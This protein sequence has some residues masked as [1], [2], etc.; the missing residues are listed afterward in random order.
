MFQM[1]RG[2]A[3]NDKRREVP[4][5]FLRAQLAQAAAGKA[6]ADGKRQRAP[7]R[8][9]HGGHRGEGADHRAGVRPGDQADEKRPFQRQVRRVVAQ[10]DA[11]GDAGNER[12]AE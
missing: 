11:G 3:E 1:R 2:S 7:F 5:G 12:N 9:D 10:Q 6:A 8:R 4:D